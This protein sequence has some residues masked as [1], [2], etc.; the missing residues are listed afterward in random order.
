MEIRH[1]CDDTC[2]R[3]GVWIF[4]VCFF[5]IS[6]HRNDYNV[7]HFSILIFKHAYASDSHSHPYL[8]IQRG[9]YLIRF[10]HTNADRQKP[11]RHGLWVAFTDQKMPHQLLGRLHSCAGQPGTRYVADAGNVVEHA[12]LEW[13]RNKCVELFGCGVGQQHWCVCVLG[14]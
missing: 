7:F 1:S 14:V 2:A 12:V 9:H 11:V 10:L 6:S 3:W 8:F 13:G 4:W 5:W